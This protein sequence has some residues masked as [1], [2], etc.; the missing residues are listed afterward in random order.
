MEKWWVMTESNRRHLPCKGSALPTELITHY[1]FDSS[2][3][4]LYEIYN[5]TIVSSPKKQF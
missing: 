4:D 5:Y 3:N 2:T 1:L